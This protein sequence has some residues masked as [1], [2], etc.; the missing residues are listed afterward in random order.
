MPPLPPVLLMPVAEAAVSSAQKLELSS[1]ALGVAHVARWEVAE[2][3]AVSALALPKAPEAPVEEK[4]MARF[5]G[6]VPDPYSP[7]MVKVTPW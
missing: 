6:P 1:A 3:V 2:A 5:L 4:S 7:V